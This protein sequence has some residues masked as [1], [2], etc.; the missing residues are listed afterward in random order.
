MIGQIWHIAWRNIMHRPFRALFLL[1]GYGLG[2][3]VM[4]A[5]LS[6]GEAMVTQASEERLVG[7]GNLTVLPDGVDVE[8]LKTGG[9]G[10]MFFSVPNARFVY[11]H[12]LASPRNRDV[13]EAVAPQLDNKL[14]YLQRMQSDGTL[15]DIPVRAFGELP[16]ATRAVGAAPQLAAGVWANDDADDRWATPTLAERRHDIDR[17]HLPPSDVAARES[18]GEWHYFNVLSDDAQR[19]AFI[20]FIVG[21]DV[22]GN[23]WGGQV[24]VTLHERG[25]SARRFVREVPGARVRFSTTDA[26]VRIGDASVTVRDD[27]AYVVQGRLVE[28]ESGVP[29]TLDLVVQPVPHAEF[30]GATLASGDFTS[31]YTVPGLRAQ[32]TGSVCVGGELPRCE[33]YSESRAYHDHNWGVWQGV[34]WEWG[35]ARADHIGVLFGRVQPPDSLE[36]DAPLFVYMTDSLGFVSL[37]RPRSVEYTDGRTVSVNG[38]VV[39]VPSFGVI[40]EV[41]GADSLRIELTVDDAVATDTRLGLADRG[42]SPL[43]RE[44]AR[45]Y[46]VQ[47]QGRVRIVARIRGVR[48]DVTGTGFF[49]T[50][51]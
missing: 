32:A 42:E 48:T 47:M 29:L 34:T 50:Y 51:R 31:G 44:L 23:Q 19:W 1:V 9:L 49:E 16:N 7:G 40:E 45:P 36:S 10:G 33:Q 15:L 41:R 14:V 4:I 24:L 20:S 11:Q 39:R 2:V 6:V 30:P 13:V 5:L 21:G 27:G 3:A 18:W 43:T 26:D 38:R 17:F 8:V 22:L 35:A 12:V 25:R 37:F 28:Q 46:F